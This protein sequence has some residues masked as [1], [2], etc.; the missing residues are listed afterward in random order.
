MKQ[1]PDQVIILIF[2]K[3]S[4]KNSYYFV[5]AEPFCD[6][7]QSCKELWLSIRTYAKISLSKYKLKLAKVGPVTYVQISQN[8]AICR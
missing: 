3:K 7:K 5:I 1:N 4:P 8:T 6:Q 2:L